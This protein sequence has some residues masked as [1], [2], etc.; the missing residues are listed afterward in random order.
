MA[1]SEI[2]ILTAENKDT[3]GK[4]EI[5]IIGKS[6][7]DGAV[8]VVIDNS[9]PVFFIERESHIDLPGVQFSRKE[10]G[11]KSF[12]G[13]LLD[14]VYFRTRNDMQAAAEALRA[15]QIRTYEADI[16]PVKR[17]LMERFIN[18]QMSVEGEAAH[19]GKT[20]CYKNP[21]V[22]AA[23]V[24]PSFGVLSLDIETSGDGKV[25]YSIAVHLQDNGKEEKKVFILGAAPEGAPAHLSFFP[26]EGKLLTAFFNWLQESDP[27]IIIGWHVIGF[28]LLFLD[29]KCRQ[30]KLNFEVGRNNGRGIIKERKAG[31]YYAFVPGRVVIDG[32]FALRSSFYSFEDFK[33]ETV[34]QELLGNGKLLESEKDKIDEIENNFKNDK[35]KLAEYNLQDAILVSEIFAKTGLIDLSI[36]RAQ[37]SGM[38]LD[39]LGTMT[40]A[41]DH[42]LLPRLHRAG[43]AAPNL[44][45]IPEGQYAPGGYVFDP[46][47]GL[48]DNVGLF[49]F[50]SLYP[51]IMRTFKIDPFSR[52]HGDVD[53]IVTPG[54]YKFSRT[55][56]FLP[57]FIGK[58]MD[59]RT[60]AKKNND[61]YL[62]QA[63][64]ILMNSFYGVMGSYGCRF[65]HPHLP[66]AITNSGQ[67]FMIESRKY[68]EA[69]GYEIL[70]GDT[71]SL[72]V[73]FKPGEEL[74]ADRSGGAIAAE[75]NI[76]WKKRL[77]DE[78]QAESYLE[79]EYEKFY[80]KFA[81]TNS[82][83][84]ETGAKKRYAGLAVKGGK[85]EIG[86]TG[87]EAVRSDWTKLAKD[88]QYE[89]YARLF[90]GKDIDEW[91]RTYIRDIKAGRYNNKLVYRKRLRKELETYTKNIPPHARAAKLINRTYG[92]IEYVMTKRGP[93]PIELECGDIDHEHY[94]EK[95]IKPIADSALSLIGKS[96]DQI[97]RESQFEMF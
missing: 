36:K 76:Y 90:Y 89:L 67:W 38:L 43:Y 77:A 24:Q 81:A 3:R 97:V 11:M 40:A 1:S 2:F 72:F 32:P 92:S 80:R 74:D 66:T 54:G 84:S 18:C 63:I 96:F 50:K 41:F 28:D 8:E 27:D 95:Q 78:F 30:L 17:Y 21:K 33:L 94:I 34:A 49:D 65:Y 9:N 82:R 6:A 68:L 26:G 19:N 87:M 48:Y 53:T 46:K 25:L 13:E 47:A 58:L 42:F 16:D 83:N 31:G 61:K 73:K 39:N 44:L 93:I 51:S 79:I 12:S 75:L 85:E 14:A 88:F 59:L 35:L 70:Y 29:N 5:R 55:K 62:S 69:K 57:D 15:K 71:D 56:N 10:I 60:E 64:K 23:E 91:L 7:R 37:L 22:K 4:N 45:D 20:L 86:F 52:L